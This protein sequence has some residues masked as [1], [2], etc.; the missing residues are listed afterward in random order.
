MIFYASP[1]DL[2]ERGLIEQLPQSRFDQAARD[3]LPFFEMS[4]HAPLYH[5]PHKTEDVWVIGQGNVAFDTAQTLLSLSAIVEKNGVSTF[6]LDIMQFLSR[7]LQAAFTMKDLHV[8]A[9]PAGATPLLRTGHVVPA[10][11]HHANFLRRSTISHWTSYSL[12]AGAYWMVPVA[13]RGVDARRWAATGARG[14]LTTWMVDAYAVVDAILADYLDGR[15]ATAV[16]LASGAYSDDEFVAD[17]VV[18]E[19]V[20]REGVA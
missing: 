18:L 5:P 10:L 13:L 15:A 19:S 9:V 7:P 6:V 20:P 8:R 1:S 11:R 17:D 3:H 14:V 2:R 16:P 12:A 4:R